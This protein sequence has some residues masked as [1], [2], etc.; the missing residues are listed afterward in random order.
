MGNDIHHT[1]GHVRLQDSDTML[2]R[3]FKGENEF[4]GD[5][6]LNKMFLSPDFDQH[7]NW[8]FDL[9]TLGTK[10]NAITTEISAV[11]FDFRT[12]KPFAEITLHLDIDDQ[13]NL[14]G[15]KV[16]GDTIAFWMAQSNE[17]REK[18]M[19]SSKQY[20]KD[21]GLPRPLMV[22]EALSTLSSFIRK[23]SKAWAM[24]NENASNEP[25]VWGN[26]ISFDLG[27]VT[28]LYETADLCLPW[29]Y[30]AE[31]DARTMCSCA[32]AIKSAFGKDFQGVPHYGLDD[33]KHEMRY[34]CAI[35]KEIQLAGEA[36][37]AK[38]ALLNE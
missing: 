23:H 29:Q 26:G 6:D 20:C 25:L 18:V 36:V 2:P 21:N 15:R 22:G 24:T 30:W 34:L 35:H 13:S 33:C 1:L 38:M 3:Y 27:K 28:N 10:L 5:A 11:G 32:P 31:R 19:H 7:L 17:A 8:V 14:Y 16:S 37:Q 9:E 12:N 4:Y